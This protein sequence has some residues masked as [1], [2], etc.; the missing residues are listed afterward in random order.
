MTVR[1][2]VVIEDQMVVVE[3]GTQASTFV[4][5]R[6]TGHQLARY[7]I[8]AVQH[9]TAAPYISFEDPEDPTFVDEIKIFEDA[10]KIV[11]V[12]FDAPNDTSTPAGVHPYGI[13]VEPAE[14]VEQGTAVEEGDL[15]I[16]AIHAVDV[17]LRPAG[18]AGR[19]KGKQRL[20]I[21]NRGS[22]PITVAVDATDDEDNTRLQFAFSQAHD[23][24]RIPGGGTADAFFNVRPDKVLPLGKPVDHAYRV[25]YRRRAEKRASVGS[26]PTSGGEVELDV[27][28]A[29]TQKPVVS[30]WMIVVGVLVIALVAALVIWRQATK[31]PD[32][33][34]ALD[35]PRITQAV[36]VTPDLLTINLERVDS[37]ARFLK[38]EQIV[39]CTATD[40]LNAN[41][42]ELGTVELTEGQQS[43]VTIPGDYDATKP[44]CFR[45]RT[46][47]SDADGSLRSRWVLRNLQNNVSVPGTPTD[48]DVKFDAENSLLIIEWVAPPDVAGSGDVEYEVLVNGQLRKATIQTRESISIDDELRGVDVFTVAVRAVLNGIPGDTAEQTSRLSELE[49]PPPVL[50]PPEDVWIAFSAGSTSR[51]DV[52]DNAATFAVGAVGIS[53]VVV[54]QVGVDFAVPEELADIYRFEGFLAYRD[55]LS[56]GEA[57]DLCLRFNTMATGVADIAPACWVYE[58]GVAPELP[59][60]DPPGE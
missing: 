7:R 40:F 37:D 22:D 52:Q 1:P 21:T 16:G 57:V 23:R 25:V 58:S 33:A 46:Q 43:V 45:A 17:R 10:V 34:G 29:Y 42:S 55:G 15:S 51:E 19:F 24:L 3:P 59:L 30:K 9:S 31:P 18:S 8:S 5:V 11:K 32:L 28:G 35:P 49:P 60:P 53:G 6:N 47:E 20:E 36:Q 13:L 4:K 27:P 50:D 54:E 26:G 14:G 44:A 39:D 56:R 12:V 2:E 38:V 41:T 48:V